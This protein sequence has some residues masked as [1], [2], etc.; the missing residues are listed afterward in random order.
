MKVLLPAILSGVASRKDKSY[1]LKF[2]TRELR[3]SEAATLLDTLQSEGWLLYAPNDDLTEADIPTEK[4]DA[5][6]GGKSPSQRQRAIIFRLWE[7][8]GRNGDFESYYRS[9]MENLNDLLKEKLD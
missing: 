6:M 5:S 1:T 8:R 3:G 9:T 4:A 7:Q 2:E